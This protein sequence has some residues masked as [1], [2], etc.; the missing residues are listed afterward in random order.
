M[1]EIIFLLLIFS[2][3]LQAQKVVITDDDRQYWAYKPLEVP[4]LPVVEGNNW[5]KHPIDQFILRGLKKHNLTPAI[6]AD[7]RSLIRRAYIDLI[8]LP[9]KAPEVEAFVQSN[10]PQAYEKIIDQLLSSPRYGERWGRHWLD[11]VRY[12]ESDGYRGDFYRPTAYKY[13]DY[14]I[15]SF[16]QDKSYQQFVMEQLAGD[17]IAPEDPEALTATGYFRLPIY[18]WNQRDAETHWETILQDITDVTADVFLGSGLQCAKC[19]DHKFDP[20]LRKDYYALKAFFA[21]IVWRDDIHLETPIKQKLLKQWKEGN[22]ETLDAIAK[23]EAPHRKKAYKKAIIMFPDEV[24]DIMAKPE[25]ERDTYEKQIAYLVM[26]QA[27]HEWNRPS[28]KKKIKDKL[29]ELKAKL[30]KK[31]TLLKG[32]TA[33]DAGP[34]AP[35]NKIPGSD[36]DILP[37]FMT[38]LYPKGADVD[39]KVTVPTKAPQS[40]GRRTSLA[41]WITNPNNP[42][43]TRVIVNRIWQYHFGRGIAANPN[44]FG[45]LG[46][47]PTHPE[48]LDWLVEQF[49]QNEW[50]FKPMHKLIMMSKTYRQSSQHKNMA[51]YMNKDPNN[52]QLWRMSDK[53]LDAEALRD[54][55]LAVSGELKQREKGGSSVSGNSPNRSIY[56]KVV[57][58]EKDEFLNAFDWADS[59]ASNA[60]RNVTTTPVQSLL[61]MNGPWV[62]KRSEALASRLVRSKQLNKDEIVKNIYSRAYGRF[63]SQNE[64]TM[65]KEFIDYQQQ[66]HQNRDTGLQEKNTHYAKMKNGLN[67]ISSNGQNDFIHFLA[68]DVQM[69]TDG[70][71]TIEAK[72]QLNAYHNEKN[73]MRMIASQNANGDSLSWALGIAGTQSKYP[74]GTLVLKLWDIKKS[75]YLISD[76]QLHLNKS[77]YIGVIADT[78]GE[79][80]T[81]KFFVKDYS[82][83]NSPINDFQTVTKKV[84]KNRESNGSVVLFSD[85]KEK[86]LDAMIGELKLTRKALDPKD[87]LINSSPTSHSSTIAHWHFASEK[88]LLKDAS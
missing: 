18:E 25:N 73:K 40:T 34:T 21:P 85:Q 7:K 52:H 15:R 59:F 67:A 54:S 30:T 35:S 20:I 33:S 51:E 39:A 60:V 32:M 81:V 49:K 68:E 17:E 47:K 19:H 38:V 9:P 74:P 16:N 10:D 45:K 42:L 46:E 28:S 86:S 71:F 3:F 88:E 48:L 4:E 83:N 58:N 55:M 31:P 62:M 50:R 72:V 87:F 8:G 5:S 56:V 65:S 78:N 1:K 26:R 12:A 23:L 44:D 22:R 64:L 36:K 70:D 29:A 57:R 84:M 43:T 41:K 66:F 79:E 63:P 61:M 75:D 2:Y 80:T 14:V 13:R 77:Y 76:L 24:Q 53:R 69:L 37:G 11:L 82:S 6:E 27:L